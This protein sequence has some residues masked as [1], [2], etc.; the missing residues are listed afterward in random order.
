MNDDKNLKLVPWNENN[1]LLTNDDVYGI[2][3]VG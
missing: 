1:R 3:L 2:F